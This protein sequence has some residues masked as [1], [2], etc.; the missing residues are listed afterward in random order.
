MLG[1][2]GMTYHE[3]RLTSAL[4]KTG[5][6]INLTHTDDGWSL[7][8]AHRHEGGLLGDCV[9]ATYSGLSW[10]EV[11]DVIDAEMLTVCSGIPTPT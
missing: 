7:T 6:W 4:F 5:G 8:I 3:P 9:S 11:L 2:R 1:F 10:S